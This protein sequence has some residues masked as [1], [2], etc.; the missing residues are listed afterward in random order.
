[1]NSYI[2]HFKDIDKTKHELVGGKC[3]NLGELFGIEGIQVPE[4]ICV[5]TGAYKEI[6]SGN[7]E[8][9]SLLDRLTTLKSA[10]GDAIREISRKIRRTIE[11]ISIPGSFVNELSRQLEQ[12]GE[13]NTYAVRSSAT[14]EDLATTSFAG[15]QDTFLNVIGR[16]AILQHI[17]KCWA[18][19][20]NDRAVAYR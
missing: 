15:Q 10:G 18:S 11:A 13:N 12:L 7:D 16:E 3:A 4:G 19:L 1:M 6:V 20:F 17:S 8:F 2:L 5:T 14:A 9:N